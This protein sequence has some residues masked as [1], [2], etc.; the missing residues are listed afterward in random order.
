MRSA[1]RSAR[2]SPSFEHARE[3]LG[4]EVHLSRPKRYSAAIAS[5]AR[6]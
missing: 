6:C 1:A 4:R 3:F 5:E 2:V